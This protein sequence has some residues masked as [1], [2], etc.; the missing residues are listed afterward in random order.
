MQAGQPSRTALGAAGHRAAHQVLERGF[1]FNDPLAVRILGDDANAIIE[2]ARSDAS[3]RPLRLFIAA[4]SRYAEDSL[5]SAVACGVRQVVVL[6]AGLDT[7]A[8]RS[9]PRVNLRIYE[10]DHPST[11]EWKRARLSTAGIA[12][13]RSLT[14]TPVDFEHESVAQNLAASGF[15]A[16]R[17]AFFTWLGVVPYLTEDAVLATLGFIASLSGGAHVVFDYANPPHAMS[18][19]ARAIH[20]KL[21]ARVLSVGE[22]FHTYWETERLHARLRE[23]GYRQIEDLGP[24]DIAARF[25][26]GRAG[27]VSDRGGHILHAATTS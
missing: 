20:D 24:V 19:A 27:A 17:P 25:L 6:G 4:R 13:P 14:Y 18:G 21:A 9:D 3:T 7:L 23:L 2:H 1:I 11:Q 5:R 22:K 16:T 10:V 26:P 8:Y 12:V 15:D